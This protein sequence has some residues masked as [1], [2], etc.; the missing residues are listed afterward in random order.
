M[1]SSRN[2][3]ARMESLW[4]Q[5]RE[6]AFWLSPELRLT[7]VNRAWEHL[8]GC[9]ADEVAGLVC[10]AHGP[11]RAGDLPGLLG[12]F[13]PPAEALSGH[14]AAEQTLIIHSSGERRWRRIEFRPFHDEKGELLGILGLIGSPAAPALGSDAESL[15]LRTELLA[16]RERLQARHGFDS[17]IGEG[18]IHRRLLDQIETAA[19]TSVPVLIVG[20]A[21]TGKRT[22][23]RT[24][25]QLGRRGQSPILPI[26]CAALPAEVLERELFGG[27]STPR[28]TLPEGSSLMIGD[29]L[30]LPRD[31]QSR[32]AATIDLRVR[33][34]A[35]TTG[36]PEAA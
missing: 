35:T 4:E 26:D 14:P 20:E 36:D 3:G 15:R 8:T 12:S 2:S 25:H 7:W 19:A 22:V 21:G 5:A 33:V 11:T 10:R 30:D 29:I 1:A 28:L 31:L 9:S 18:P 23:A 34:L 24:I 27:E 13:Y 6:P 17:L 32:L 16:V